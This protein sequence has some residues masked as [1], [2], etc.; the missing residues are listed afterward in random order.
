MPRGYSVH[1]NDI[2]AQHAE[3]VKADIVI[4][5]YD[6]WVFSP[7]VTQ[8]FRWCPWAPI[9]HDPAPPPVVRAL[10]VAWQ[11][12]CY[13]KFGFQKLQEAGLDPRYVPHGI[14]TKVFVPK[15]RAEARRALKLPD[16]EIDFLA[17]MVAANKGAP[18][19]KSFPE[20]FWA[21]RCFVEDHPKAVLFIHTH[22]GAE[23]SGLDLVELLKEMEMPSKAVIFCDP[24]WNVV[25][26]PSRYMCNLYNAADVL[27]NP[28]YGEGFGLPIMEA[29]ACGT[30]VIVNTCTSMPELLFAGWKTDNQS[31]YT[32]QG[33]WQFTPKIA[34][35]LDA[36]KE[37]YKTKGYDKLRRDA[38]KG[39]EQYDADI[40]TE[41]Y[42]K[43]V[44]AEIADELKSGQLEMVSV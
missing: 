10:Q 32:P 20:V 23:M 44:L 26:Y 24:Y 33:S 17:I 4:T 6:S 27:I 28:A 9:D 3:Y 12:I 22:A 15:D 1:G 37:A 38:R 29:Q 18:S 39:A 19:R 13:S 30:P 8:Q 2:L 34:D 14:D 42:W 16:E 41:R 21:W 31:F 40:V 7:S 35:I 5:L 43:P 36:L 11:P 25:G